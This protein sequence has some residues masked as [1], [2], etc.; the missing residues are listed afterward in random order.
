MTLRGFFSPIGSLI[1]RP[2]RFAGGCRASLNTG[3]SSIV[4]ISAALESLVDICDLAIILFSGPMFTTV[5]FRARL[6]AYFSNL[7]N[8]NS[9]LPRRATPRFRIS[10]PRWVKRHLTTGCWARL[11]RIPPGYARECIHT[12][13]SPIITPGPCDRLRDIFVTMHSERIGARALG[14]MASSRRRH[15]C[16]NRM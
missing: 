8:L 6:P 12:G 4:L 10:S 15:T 16:G 5:S 9:R 2:A 14:P 7:T 11:C 13:F 3:P 1:L